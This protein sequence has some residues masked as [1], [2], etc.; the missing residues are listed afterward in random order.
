MTPERFKRI[1]EVLSSRTT[2][3]TVVMDQVHKPHNLSAI[4]RTCDAVGVLEAHA[5]VPARSSFRADHFT[6]GGSG[7]WVKVRSHPAVAS[8]IDHLARGGFQIIAAH[9]SSTA[10]PPEQ[11]DLTRPTAL[12]MGAELRGVSAEGL[13]LA[14][15]TTAIPMLGM[16]GSLNVSVATAVILFEALRQ[17]S[18]D[19]SY[20]P[21]RIPQ[22]EQDRL[23]VEWSYPKL[24]AICRA[25]GLSYP[26]V[27]DEGYLVD[28]EPTKGKDE[29]LSSRR[30]AV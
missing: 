3:L 11:I 5:V 20:R 1:L 14:H 16:V 19:S 7:Q 6:A 29:P 4:L 23:A 15:Q 13:A 27:D 21:A 2:D 9:P 17:R 24:T 10:V 12:L 8:A 22:A 28:S 30:R 25:K 18:L 26:L